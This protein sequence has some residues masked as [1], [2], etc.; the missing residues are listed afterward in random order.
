MGRNMEIKVY[1]GRF[2]YENF[3]F[4]YDVDMEVIPSKGD[5]IFY[6][7]EIYKVLYC[8]IDVDNN[9]Y[10]VFVRATSEEDF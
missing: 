2:G 6:E 8:M 1:K 9:I 3:L 7:E 10:N 4:N 5:F